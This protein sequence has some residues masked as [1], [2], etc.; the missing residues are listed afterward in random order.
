MTVT[1]RAGRP[2]DA[3]Q[4]GR[5]CY[6]AFKAIA[7]QHN[8]P[9]DFPTREVAVGL[10]SMMLSHGGFH[11]V[12]AELDGRIVGSN[13]LDERSTIAGVGP[14]TVDPAVQN[15][16]VGRELM[17]RVLERAGERRFPGVRLVQDAFHNRSLCLYTKLGFE[18]REPLS[19]LQGTAIAEL[20]PGY[21]VRPA[22]D[23]DLRACNELCARV[24][25]H[26]RAGELSDAIRQGTA[27]VVERAGR[28]TGYSTSVAFFGH[29]VGDTNEDVEALIAAAPAF[30]GPGFIVPTRNGELLR[31]CLGHGLRLVKQMTLMTIGLYN[32]PRGAYLPSIL[33]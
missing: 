4:C 15:Q 3:E 25:G 2:P 31:W 9:P 27:T 24:H 7:E 14:I 6:E 17:Q 8:F 21:A 11:S 33:Y 18:T 1:L 20:I 16:S 26:E 22:S 29:A 32:E 19:T 13:F 12:V 28:M 10:L 30:P 23:R 5:I